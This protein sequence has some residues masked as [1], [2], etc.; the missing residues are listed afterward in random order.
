[1]HILCGRKSNMKGVQMWSESYTTHKIGKKS[2]TGNL[3]EIG[4]VL[5]YISI[6]TLEYHSVKSQ[7]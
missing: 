4:Q 7:Q 3:D 1:M 6:L 2:N 5:D